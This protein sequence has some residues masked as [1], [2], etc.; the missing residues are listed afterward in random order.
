MD[1]NYIIFN[2][3]TSA[4]NAKNLLLRNHLYCKLVRTP[5][6]L[7]TKSCG[8]SLLVPK[9]VGEAIDLITRNNIQILGVSAVDEQ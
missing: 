1:N 3:L 8:Y 6:N 5:I 4:M 2:S 9:N 7:R